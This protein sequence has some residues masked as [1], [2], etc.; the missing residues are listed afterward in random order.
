MNVHQHSMNSLVNSATRLREYPMT[1]HQSL[2][3]TA[4][5][6][7]E[8]LGYLTTNTAIALRNRGVDPAAFERRA[9]DSAY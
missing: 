7:V 4:R 9:L 6:E 2:T 8:A 5:K 1:N 3:A